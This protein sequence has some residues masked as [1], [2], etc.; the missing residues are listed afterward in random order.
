MSHLTDVKKI[1]D[2]GE[3]PELEW[4]TRTGPVQLVFYRAEP[5]G[6]R[7]T[8]VFAYLAIPERGRA[9]FPAVALVHGGGGKAFPEW[10]TMWAQRGYVALAMDLAGCGPDGLRHEFA[11]PGQDDGAKFHGL[12]HGV[13]E[14]WMY[15]AVA[16][17]LH[18]VSVLATRPEVDPERIAVTGISWGA[19]VAEIAVALDPRAKA[20]SFVYGCGYIRDNP[21]WSPALDAMPPDLADLWVHEFDASRYVERLSVPTLWITGAKDA[22]YP[23]DRF[24]RSHRLLRAP[25]RL[26]VTPDFEHSHPDGWSPLEICTFF[27]AHLTNGTPLPSVDDVR[28]DGDAIVARFH[29][30][31]PITGAWVHSTTDEVA[32]SQRSWLSTPADLDGSLVRGLVPDHATACLVTVDDIRGVVASSEYVDLLGG[33][34]T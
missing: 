2:E 4:I 21:T 29:S 31:L 23:L 32:W 3:T 10:A 17:V 33:G 16:D 25:R 24:Q 18:G 20:A 15:H 9:P 13:K 30:E 14:T 7:P 28:L 5:F 8:K 34:A 26:R 6:G 1:A 22:F 11:G 12:A 27:D 19:H